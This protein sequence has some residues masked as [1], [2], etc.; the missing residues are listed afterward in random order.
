MPSRVINPTNMEGPSPS[1]RSRKRCRLRCATSS[2]CLRAVLFWY[3]SYVSRLRTPLT[4]HAQPLPVCTVLPSP[5][6][7]PPVYVLDELIHRPPLR[8]AVETVV[9]KGRLLGFHLIEC[10]P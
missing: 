9:F 2:I 8:T 7:Q 6:T 4:I 1:M 3:T 10:H 5:I